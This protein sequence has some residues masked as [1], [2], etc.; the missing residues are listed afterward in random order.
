MKKLLIVLLFCLPISLFALTPVSESEWNGAESNANT[1]LLNSTISAKLSNQWGY[2]LDY[3]SFTPASNTTTTFE[4]SSGT[5]LK[6]E[7]I[8]HCAQTN[9]TVV[10]SA[11]SPPNIMT[12]ALA[13]NTKYCIKVSYAQMGVEIPYVLTLSSNQSPIANHKFFPIPKNTPLSTNIMTNGGVADSDPD[14]DTL[15]VAKKTDPL[16][17]TITLNSNGNL[18]YVPRT[19]FTGTDSFVYILSDSAGHSVEANVIIEVSN[20]HPLA[21]D[22]YFGTPIDTLLS[23]NVMSEGGLVDSDPSGGSIG[24]SEWTNPTHGTLSLK[25]NGDFIY[26]PNS[27]FLGTDTFTYAIVNQNQLSASATVFIQVYDNGD[28]FVPSFDTASVGVVCGVFEDV[29]QTHKHKSTINLIGSTAISSGGCVLNTSEITNGGWQTLTCPNGSAMASGIESSALSVQY[30]NPPDTSAVT[31]SPNS[32]S[33]DVS[34]SSNETLTQS[35]YRKIAFTWTAPHVPLSV[36]FSNVTKI[37][38]I[39]FTVDNTVSFSTPTPYNLEIGTVSG[40]ANSVLKTNTVPKNIKIKTFTLSSG[41]KVDFEAAQTIQ[42]D[43]AQFA[44]DDSSIHL[45]APY[46]KIGHLRQDQSGSEGRSY[47]TITAD[48]IDI[49]HLDLSEL[50]T[51]TIKPYTPGKRILFRSN[52]ITA[53]ST[54]TMI[55]SSGN[56]YTKEFNIPGTSDS[57]SIRALDDKQLINLFIDGDFKPGNNPGI[58]SDGNKGNYGD[59]PAANFLMF[60]KG[61]L[62]TGGGGTTFNAT[63]YVEGTTVFGSPSYLKGALSSGGNI[64]LNQGVELWYDQTISEG[65]WAACTQNPVVLV[66]IGNLDA[67]DSFAAGYTAGRGL[68]TKVANKDNYT[69]DVLY[70]GEEGTPVAYGGSTPL[71]VL[72]ALSDAACGT[73]TAQLTSAMI[74][75]GAKSATSSS[76][77]MVSHAQKEARVRFYYLDLDNLPGGNHSNCLNSSAGAN[78]LKGVPACFNSHK[79]LEDAFGAEIAAKCGA[80][81]R[82][83]CK[84]SSYANGLPNAPYDNDYGCLACLADVL[85]GPKCSSDLFAIRP[86]RFTSDL[87]AN[88]Q[89]IAG[90]ENLIT[91]QAKQFEGDGTIGYHEVENSSFVVDVN[92]SD[93]SKICAETSINFSP[94]IAF[95]DGAV[96]QSYNLPNV[97]DYNLTIYEKPGFEFALVDADDTPDNERYIAPYVQQVSI[98]P[99]HFLVEGTFGNS[100]EDFSY[101]SDFVKNPTPAA[102]NVSALLDL[103]VTARNALNV[104][105]SNYTALCYAKDGNITL[106]TNTQGTDLVGLNHLLWYETEH[107]VNGTIPLGSGVNYEMAMK[108]V[109][110]D[111]VATEGMA[112]VK[113]RINFDRQTNVAVEPFVF[114]AIGV[115]VSNE[116]DRNG[117]IALNQNATFSMDVFMRQS[118]V[119]GEKVEQ[120]GCIM[121]C[122]AGI[123]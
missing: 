82:P 28:E 29:L 76:F 86:E 114:H 96:I 119:S 17:G 122:I 12:F 81:G 77:Q 115:D 57:S 4:I 101:L 20:Q 103:N 50:A 121:R 63:I 6:I 84:S 61:N 102:R 21:N 58:N 15:S 62:E 5:P 56:Y 93:T 71:F 109:Q 22:K 83:A 36:D 87:E 35:A 23:K 39:V 100:G 120:H 94:S 68:K 60:V 32:A 19:D 113:Y 98:V 79:K 8:E 47:V 30:S 110:F 99:D 78:A 34:V 64:H 25:G 72:L 91:F 111:S 42:M 55:V 51:L 97:G 73:P 92:I 11:I 85:N 107:D 18:L 104:P 75:S 9:S 1:V 67:V 27:A 48:Y 123:V 52:R 43:K 59:L 3:F 108:G 37:N 53:S 44:R 33:L 26:S 54:N 10:S 112:E 70:L 105:T 116:D 66:N 46:V 24:V 118:T 80:G 40:N 16:H 31:L 69:V 74:P 7:L 14:G 117:T 89:L 38:E 106:R 2:D 41:A 49:G 45:K 90:G 65:G 88:Q 13:S 95:V